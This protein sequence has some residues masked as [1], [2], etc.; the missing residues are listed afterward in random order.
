MKRR[1]SQKI[2]LV[3]E[4]LLRDDNGREL[5]HEKIVTEQNPHPLCGSSFAKELIKTSPIARR[6]LNSEKISRQGTYPSGE[7]IFFVMIICV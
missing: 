4:H 5:E 7:E 1:S 3:E 2:P 6:G